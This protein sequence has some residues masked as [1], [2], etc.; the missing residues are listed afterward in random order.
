MIIE[1]AFLKLPEL[2]T[3]KSDHHGTLEATVVNFFSVAILM[4]LNSRNVPKAFG[5]LHSEKPYPTKDKSGNPLRADLFVK[6][7]GVF[8]FPA[9]MEV[10]GAESE[11]WI[12]AK[13]FFASARR[14]NSASPKTREAGKILKDLLRLCLLPSLGP[15]GRYLLLVFAGEASESVALQGRNQDRKWLSGL[16]TEGLTDVQVNLMDEPK[17][18]KEAIGP[19]FV[20]PY[21]LEMRL[22][23]HTM[24]FQPHSCT[25][26]GSYPLFRG[27]L[28]RIHGFRIRTSSFDVDCRGE[29]G[30]TWCSDVEQFK[31][32]QQEI[33][34]RF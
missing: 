12:E 29:L 9:R 10:Y 32:L 31:K 13:T 21:E 16:L 30:Q 20:Q 34:K 2:L 18:L 4:E 23:L 11:N 33:R 15:S 8:P 7:D 17:V 14:S 28:V 26:R 3:S 19:G 27:Y 24:I 6:L 1:S 25:T 5:R 22:R